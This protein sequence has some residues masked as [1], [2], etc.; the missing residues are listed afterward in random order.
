MLYAVCILRLA[1]FTLFP[2]SS[3]MVQ[4]LVELRVASNISPP[5]GQVVC[6]NGGR[7]CE[8]VYHVIDE[9]G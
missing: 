1:L 6:H 7:S 2:E 3:I 8:P 9:F 4:S 5:V